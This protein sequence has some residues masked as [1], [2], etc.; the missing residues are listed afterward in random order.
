MYPIANFTTPGDWISYASTATSGMFWN[1]ILV[2][3][4]MI[5]FGTFQKSSS[6]ERGFA[7]SSFVTGLLA[8]FLLLMNGIDSWSATAWIV[9]SFA[10]FILLLFNRD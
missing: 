6:V 4:F 9:L 3:I 7:A 10:G 1:L 5:M 2:A 8:I